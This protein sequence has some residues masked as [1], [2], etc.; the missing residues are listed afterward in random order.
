MVYTPRELRV[1]WISG[2]LGM[3]WLWHCFV[4]NVCDRSSA[5]ASPEQL[6]KA[7]LCVLCKGISALQGGGVHERLIGIHSFIHSSKIK[8]LPLSEEGGWLLC[9]SIGLLRVSDHFIW[10]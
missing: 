6:A 9:F 4:A 8:G 7:T 10:K 2:S 3:S 1:D 5:P